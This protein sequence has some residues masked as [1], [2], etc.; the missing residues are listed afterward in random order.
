MA[1]YD[2][3]VAEP[4]L[5]PIEFDETDLKGMQKL[6]GAHLQGL[7]STS[8][9]FDLPKDI[10]NVVEELSKYNAIAVPAFVEK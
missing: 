1:F 6:W 4:L 5:H 3:S 7:G 10:V 2:L 8:Q 9:Y